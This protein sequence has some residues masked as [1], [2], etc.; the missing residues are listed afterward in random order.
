MPHLARWDEKLVLFTATGFGLGRIPVAPGT[1]GTLAGLP[2]IWILSA[3]GPALAAFL[4]TGFVLVSVYVA[5]RASTLMGKKDPGA[6]VIDEMV[7]YCVAMTLVPL[8]LSTLIAGFLAFR[9]FDI[10]KPGPVRYFE[11]YS[12][13]AGIVLDDMMA[14]W[15]AAVVV[16]CL[17][18]WGLI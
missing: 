3:A 5:D 12:G 7:G 8:S 2:L 1:F 10:L 13:G 16:K 14:G 18:L 4:L 17:H 6:V 9:C 11:G 15:L